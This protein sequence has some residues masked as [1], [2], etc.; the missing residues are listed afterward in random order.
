MACTCLRAS[1]AR[2]T[3]TAASTRSIDT[4]RAAEPGAPGRPGERDGGRVPVGALGVGAPQCD[5]GQCPTPLVDRGREARR[6]ASAADRVDQ[7]AGP[8]LVAAGRRDERLGQPQ[9]RVDGRTGR[10]AEREPLLGEPTGL[11]P[12]SRRDVGG[13]EQAERR[14]RGPTTPGGVDGPPQRLAALRHPVEGEADRGDAHDANGIGLV[15]QSA[16]RG[17]DRSDGRP[18]RPAASAGTPACG[19][20]SPSG[21][22]GAGPPSAVEGRATRDVSIG[23]RLRAES[24]WSSEGR[25]RRGHRS[26]RPPGDRGARTRIAWWG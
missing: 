1:S 25:A 17:V 24:E 19:P 14:R 13:A 9:R 12:A 20:R 2:P 4:R 22:H 6:P 18:G 8:H 7:R 3:R 11:E 21:H 16:D 5:Q 26:V 23:L 10:P 15:H